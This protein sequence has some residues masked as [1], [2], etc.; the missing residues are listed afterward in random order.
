MLY[1]VVTS[2]PI[3]KVSLITFQITRFSNKTNFNNI[4][5]NQYKML[6]ILSNSILG[7][8]HTC[9]PTYSR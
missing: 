8:L 5:K 4:C 1:V 2:I 6:P 9:L 3:G 7:M